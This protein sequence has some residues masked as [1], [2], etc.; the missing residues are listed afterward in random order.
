MQIWW[1]VVVRV[2]GVESSG[3]T[4]TTP[5]MY[6]TAEH[7]C[8]YRSEPRIASRVHQTHGSH[9]LVLN[10]QH[11]PLRRK[12]VFQVYQELHQTLLLRQN[13]V[14]EPFNN[15]LIS[16]PLPPSPPLPLPNESSPFRIGLPIPLSGLRA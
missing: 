1:S 9:D 2:H 3:T 5:L 7:G 12:E 6:A 14:R 15:P 8:L 13:Q 11:Y 16:T 10:L 4:S